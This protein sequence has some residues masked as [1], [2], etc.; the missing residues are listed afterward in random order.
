MT[1]TVKTSPTRR[2][3]AAGLV[4]V[5]L[6]FLIAM[7]A[8]ASVNALRNAFNPRGFFLTLKSADQPEWLRSSFETGFYRAGE[9]GQG[10]GGGGNGSNAE[11]DDL[12]HS[13]VRH[14][15]GE[16]GLDYVDAADVDTI[17]STYDHNPTPGKDFMIGYYKDEQAKPLEAIPDFTKYIGTPARGSGTVVDPSGGQWWN[18]PIRMDL[19]E[20]HEDGTYDAMAP[21]TLYEFAY[22]RGNQANNGTTCV[23]MPG[24]AEG[25]F[26][27]YLYNPNS[28]TEEERAEYE[29]HKYDE[30]EFI[31]AIYPEGSSSDTT[32]DH[33]IE[34]V[35]MRYHIQTYADL[36]KW[37]DSAE[38]RYAVSFL[39]S[40]TEQDYATGKYIR[41]NVEYLKT[42]KESLDKEA[43]EEVKYQL[44]KDA[45][46]TIQQM[47]EDL[48]AAQQTAESN[49]AVTDFSR[50]NKTLEDAQIAYDYIKDKKGTEV[51]QYRPEAV[52]ALDQAIRHAQ[53][54]IGKDSTQTQVDAETAA[55]ETSRVNAL[56]A[57]VRPSDEVIFTDA[58]TGIMVTAKSSSLTANSRL[59]VREVVAG[60]TEYDEM[61]TRVTPKPDRLAIY[62]ILF[63]DGVDVVHPTQPVTVQIPLLDSLEQTAPNVYYLDNTGSPAQQVNATAAQGYRIFET[64]TLGTFLVGGVL[65]NQ[66]TPQNNQTPQ[67]LTPQSVT[68]QDQNA[69]QGQNQTPQQNQN[70]NPVHTT[71]RTTT[72]TAARTTRVIRTTRNAND[73]NKQNEMTTTSVLQTQAVQPTTMTTTAPAPTSA[74]DT[75][76]LEQEPNQHTLLYIALAV[77][78]VGVGAAAYEFYKDKRNGG[79]GTD[80]NDEEL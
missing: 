46:W 17:Y 13:N 64:D 53:T 43:E 74:Q 29:A 31:T 54:T 76:D 62:R 21:G 16:T 40:V 30:Y 50:Y 24:E 9:G 25:T 19:G 48:K 7:P 15:D 35:P 4:T 27:G 12:G 67:Q 57:L 79:L 39:T 63:Y 42:T 38:Y 60:T 47:I 71:T 36:S 78:A 80:H 10:G 3:A 6:F 58:A 5:F 22:L 44:Q 66:Q 75:S 20:V 61:V 18:I 1:K 34:S 28:F 52:D 59:V 72:R 49:V 37:Y 77:A 65:Q 14:I 32:V 26:K 23:L 69:P 73:Q 11:K 56:D 33:T 2:V 45:E 70:N 68:P 8:S 51:D 41:Q 55:L